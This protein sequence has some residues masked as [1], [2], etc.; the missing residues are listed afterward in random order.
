MYRNGNI[1]PLLSVDIKLLVE[2]T[3]KRDI[4]LT[5]IDKILKK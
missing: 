2:N 1:L 4:K 5:K 3:S